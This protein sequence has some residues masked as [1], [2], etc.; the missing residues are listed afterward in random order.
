MTF[1]EA[2][3]MQLVFM[4][5]FQMIV[6]RANMRKDE[7]ILIY[8][9]SSGIGSAAIQISRDIGAKIIATV[10]NQ[11]KVEHAKKMGATDVIIHNDDNP[12]LFL[13]QASSA[14]A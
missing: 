8:G 11:N 10:G 13:L 3:S 9:G 1:P 5:A 7:T 12:F 2:S 6:N 14:W 4:T